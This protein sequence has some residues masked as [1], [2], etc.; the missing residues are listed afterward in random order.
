MTSP[1]SNPYRDQFLRYAQ[2]APG[3]SMTGQ[4][5]PED[6]NAGTVKNTMGVAKPDGFNPYA[7]GPKQYGAT[8]RSN[9]TSGPVSP[10][11]LEGYRGREQRAAVARQASLN[12]L[13]ANQSGNFA[14]PQWLGGQ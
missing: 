12:M 9:P 10:T 11:G 8:G 5:P 3:L 1:N 4:V 2:S 14:S 13:K 6:V 7:A